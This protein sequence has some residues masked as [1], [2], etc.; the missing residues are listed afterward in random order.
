MNYEELN[1]LYH[2]L[3]FIIFDD[4]QPYYSIHFNTYSI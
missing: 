3:T 1:E 4:F 2:N